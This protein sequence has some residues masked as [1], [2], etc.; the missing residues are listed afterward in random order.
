MIDAARI[1]AWLPQ[2]RWFAG[3]G[4]ALASVTVGDESAVPGTGVSLAIL[5]VATADGTDRYVAPLAADADAALDPG[6]A[7]WLVDAIQ[8]GATLP[9][10][11]GVFRGH[12]AEPGARAP[13]VGV[14]RVA[15]LG[16]DASNTS[17][18]V[19]GAGATHAVKL[20][21]RCRPGIQ[22]EVE[23]GEFLARD[24]RW[25]GTPRLRGW[26]EYVFADGAAVAV[27]TM[28]EFVP[29]CV[30]AWDHLVPLV[31]GGGLAGARRADILRL[32]GALGRTTAEMHRALASR[33]ELAAFAP[34]VA[35]VA[36][37]Q[38]EVDRMLANAADVFALATARLPA[39]PPAAAGN[40]DAPPALGP[41]E[42]HVPG[43]VDDFRR[44]VHGGRRRLLR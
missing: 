10:R 24:A 23:V 26:L 40:P 18:L 16:G 22:P 17:L 28:H 20:L 38:A 43:A 4:A 6:F 13:A 1:A 8:G 34:Q 5:D 32:A 31:A 9:G 21:R 39:L 3:K 41:K 44:D 27:A 36:D 11:T 37:R 30:T 42:T 19:E 15:P 2:A 25:A 29:G 7:A 14:A 33:P 35:T 12:P